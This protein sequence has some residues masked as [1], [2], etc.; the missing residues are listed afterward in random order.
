MRSR[1]SNGDLIGGVEE[2]RVLRTERQFPWCGS[3]SSWTSHL[4]SAT[5]EMKVF[6]LG[7]MEHSEFPGV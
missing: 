5:Q 3:L 1:Q 2:G 6:M 4:T 7:F